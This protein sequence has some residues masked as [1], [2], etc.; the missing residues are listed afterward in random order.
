[1]NADIRKAMRKQRA[2]LSAS[3]VEQ[4]SAGVVSRIFASE[5]FKAAKTVMLYR[6][7]KGEVSLE[8]LLS[9]PE[10][11]GKTLAFPL[12]I[13][14]TEMIAVVPE[15]EGSWKTGMYGIQEPVAEKSR[16][17][18][19]EEID[20][21]LCPCTAFDE[22]CNRLGMGGGYYDRFLPKCTN[23]HIAAVAYEFQKS[24]DIY[25]NRHDFKMEK[26]FTEKAVYTAK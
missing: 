17:I 6:T 26:V 21:M 13:S 2:A 19:P 3:E 1:M 10:C 12:C 11:Q 9:A 8:A 23:A 18:S 5:E 14:N 15:G 25:V 22:K 20:L 4:L 7:F 24:P 16:K